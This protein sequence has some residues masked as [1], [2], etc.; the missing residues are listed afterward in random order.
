MRM[1]RPWYVNPSAP[2]ALIWIGPIV[3]VSNLAEPPRPVPGMPHSYVNTAPAKVN[4]SKPYS[5]HCTPTNTVMLAVDA[6]QMPT[7][8]SGNG[9]ENIVSIPNAMAVPMATRKATRAGV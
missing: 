7:T 9:I 2:F 1:T 3:A 5:S 6:T 4:R 8:N